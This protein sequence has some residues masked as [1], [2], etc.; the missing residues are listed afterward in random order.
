MNYIGPL[1][2]NWGMQ[3]LAL[4]KASVLLI[5]LSLSSV[6]K[7]ALNQQLGLFSAF[8]ENLMNQPLPELKSKYNVSAFS[9]EEVKGLD[10][11]RN[12]YL[13]H[14]LRIQTSQKEYRFKIGNRYQVD[15]YEKQIENWKRIVLLNSQ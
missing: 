4:E 13:S 7:H 2:T 12:K 15:E 5:D 11:Q 3:L 6:F 1:H 14:T 9:L 10:I 8:L